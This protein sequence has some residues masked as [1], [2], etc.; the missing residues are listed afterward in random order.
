MRRTVYLC[1][2][3]LIRTML[4][5]KKR[6]ERLLSV[7]NEG[8]F[9]KEHTIALT[10]L[11]ALAG[12]SIF[13]L[14]P[15]GVAKS[16]VARRLKLAF[17]EAQAF[18]YLMSRFS[19]PDEIFGP[20][21]ISKLKDEDRYERITKGYLPTATV[22]FLDELWKAGPAIQNSLLTVVNEKIYRNGE[23]TVNVPLKVLIAASNELPA[24]GEGLEALYDRFLIRQFVGAIEQEFAFDQMVASTSEHMPIVPD[25]L[26]IGDEEYKTLQEGAKGV[27]LHY[28]FF[29][30]LH[31]IKRAIESYNIH[32]TDQQSPIF[33]SDRRWKKAVGL[34][35]MSA[36]LHGASTVSFVDCLLLTSCLWDELEQVSI[37]EEIVQQAVAENIQLLLLGEREM[38]KQIEALKEEM[39]SAHSL[40]EV[41]DAA[42]Q[43]VDTFYHRVERYPI[44]GNLLLFASDYQNLKRDTNRL[45]YLQTDK[46][47]PVNKVLKAYDFVK[48]RSVPQNQIYSLQK[49]N[50]SVF[51][52]NQEYP[53]LCNDCSEPPPSV[54]ASATSPF[55]TRLEEVQGTLHYLNTRLKTLSDEGT[56]YAN[57]HLFLSA[58]QR[59]EYKRI[60]SGVAQLLEGYTNE[61]RLITHAHDQQNREY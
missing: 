34:V 22:V 9:E 2:F 55:A 61:L 44:A 41:S 25:E 13:L 60:L 46:Y 56:K 30:L 23:M 28:T 4:E 52:N 5:V 42:I 29:E 51:I 19:T 7:L 50:R 17:K 26:A 27:E 35:R 31:T 37:I 38:E 32:H 21:S 1:I 57:T 10:M 45:F 20:V 47:R 53:L 6:M 24:K 12:E 59:M 58:K 39:K 54:E 43:V 49:G 8:V 18:E 3:K 33:V 15:P 36:H 48:H 40:Q 11:A 16:L 14:G